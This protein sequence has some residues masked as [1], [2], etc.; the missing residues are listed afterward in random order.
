MWGPGACFEW[1]FSAAP[2]WIN[3]GAGIAVHQTTTLV[4]ANGRVT[5]EFVE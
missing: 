3:P 5:V 2:L 4:C 1:D